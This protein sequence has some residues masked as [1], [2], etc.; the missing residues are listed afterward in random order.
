MGEQL[1]TPEG[2][3]GRT[4]IVPARAIRSGIAIGVN[5]RVY[6]D[7]A[8]HGSPHSRAISQAQAG[9]ARNKKA[10]RR[11]LATYAM[12]VYAFTLD[13]RRR[14]A[15]VPIKPRPARNKAYDSGS[16]IGVTGAPLF[17]SETR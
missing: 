8:I 17:E 10:P 2:G 1:E 14:L 4:G 13:F 3:R 12:L 9:L 15:M 6:P 7:Q 11:A 5:R 16:G